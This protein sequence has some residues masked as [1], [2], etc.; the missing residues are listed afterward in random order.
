MDL[1]KLAEAS[2]ITFKGKK[3][4]FLQR[5]IPN[6]LK[7]DDDFRCTHLLELWEG[8][9]ISVEKPLLSGGAS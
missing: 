1:C 3:K 6:M 5:G 7:L 9:R 2:K 4:L 8:V